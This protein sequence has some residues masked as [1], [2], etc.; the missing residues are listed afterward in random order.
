MT[1]VVAMNV[2]PTA[3]MSL[4]CY[5]T[6]PDF[7]P[8][9]IKYDFDSPSGFVCMRYK[10]TCTELAILSYPW[11]K[12]AKVG[13]LRTLYGT[14]TVSAVDAMKAATSLYKDVYGC[15]TE[16]CNYTPIAGS[17][18]PQSPAFALFSLIAMCLLV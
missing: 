17:A 5:A 4:K 7:K 2:L 1:V 10:Q 15:S 9:P 14:M 6:S 16:Y 13:S 18:M 8:V 11:C 3:I 12:G